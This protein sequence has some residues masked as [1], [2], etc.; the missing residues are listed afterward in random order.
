MADPKRVEVELSDYLSEQ[1][2]KAMKGQLSAPI[3]YR[4]ERLIDVSPRTYGHVGYA[5]LVS[6]LLHETQPDR[7]AVATMIENYRNAQVWETRHEIG[8]P[9]T[10]TG[11]WTVVLRG[12]GQRTAAE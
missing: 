9:T 5:E 6:A 7:A 11:S 3:T 10:K 12:P 2:G 8:E 4:L 1:P